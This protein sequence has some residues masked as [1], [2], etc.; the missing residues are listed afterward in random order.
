MSKWS[1]FVEYDSRRLGSVGCRG[2][3]SREEAIAW[4]Q[5]GWDWKR[6]YFMSPSW[7][8]KEEPRT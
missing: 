2:L 8:I 3:N 4:L 5:R 6:C 1:A 7:R